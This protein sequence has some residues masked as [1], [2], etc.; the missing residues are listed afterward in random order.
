MPIQRIQH[1]VIFLAVAQQAHLVK[2]ASTSQNKPRPLPAAPGGAAA[3][4]LPSPF[5]HAAIQRLQVGLTERKTVA[6]LAE[7]PARRDRM[8]YRQ[9]S[10]R[11][12]IFKGGLKQKINER[13]YMRAPSASAMVTGCTRASMVIG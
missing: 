2:L 3:E 6:D 10:R 7:I 8:I 1:Q 9:F 4:G 5:T 11:E 13:R 12:K